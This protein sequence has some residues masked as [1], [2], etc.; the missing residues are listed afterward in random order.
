MRSLTWDIESN[1]NTFP[2]PKA[3]DLIYKD[4]ITYWTIGESYNPVN[5]KSFSSPEIDTSK[6][7]SSWRHSFLLTFE[8]I[9]QMLLRV[10]VGS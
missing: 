1:P 9:A 3:K 10:D 6:Q 7:K 5:S 8:N 2:Q 4:T